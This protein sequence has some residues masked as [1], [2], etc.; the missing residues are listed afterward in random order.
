MLLRTMIPTA[1]AV[2]CVGCSTRQPAGEVFTSPGDVSGSDTLFRVLAEGKRTFRF[3]TFGNEQFWTDT[4]RLHE[5][6]QKSVSPV[7]ALAVGLK[8]D[9]EAIPAGVA[10]AIKDGQVDLNSPA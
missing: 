9:A 10:Q 6:V 7:T 2:L 5:V 4:A 1:L 8:V 3:E